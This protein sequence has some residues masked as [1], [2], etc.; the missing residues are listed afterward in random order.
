[1]WITFYFP[2]MKASCSLLYVFYQLSMC[3]K[4]GI[5]VISLRC[6]T[7]VIMELTIT[8]VMKI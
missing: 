8:C 1:M 2:W 5:C 6:I 7:I 4:K 3:E